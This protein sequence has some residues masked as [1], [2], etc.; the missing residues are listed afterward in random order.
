MSLFSKATVTTTNFEILETRS[1]TDKNPYL[2]IKARVPSHGKSLTESWCGD[3]VNLCTDGRDPTGFGRSYNHVRE[4]ASCQEKY[5]SVMDRSDALGANPNEKVAALAQQVGFS[6]ATSNNSFAFN[7]C[8]GRKCSNILPESGCDEA[9]SCISRS[10]PNREVY[11]VCIEHDTNFRAV[12]KK[13]SIVVGLRSLL[14]TV[15]A[16]AQIFQV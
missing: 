5:Q 2:V 15:K 16:S 14:L 9:L 13:W 4:Y 7:A 12:Q 1:V 11:T 8:D 3:Y 6:D 10:V